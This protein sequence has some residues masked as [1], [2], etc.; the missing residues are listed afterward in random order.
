MRKKSRI[1]LVSVI[2]VLFIILGVFMGNFDYNKLSKVRKEYKS[3]NYIEN[4]M[5]KYGSFN[6]KIKVQNKNKL[7][8][9]FFISGPIYTCPNNKMTDENLV[10][11]DG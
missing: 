10:V 3:V 8:S 6:K 7:N 11:V 2:V 9:Q 5:F 4:E 1:F